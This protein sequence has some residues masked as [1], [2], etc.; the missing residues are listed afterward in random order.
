MCVYIYIYIYICAAVVIFLSYRCV[1]TGRGDSELIVSLFEGKWS[2]SLQPM[3]ILPTP[4]GRRA[5]LHHTVHLSVAEAPHDAG[6]GGRQAAVDQVSQ[7]A[8]QPAGPANRVGCERNC[9]AQ[10]ATPYHML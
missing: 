4:C 6:Q 1:T 8:G 7:P 3:A 9:N 2:R 10:D 5:A